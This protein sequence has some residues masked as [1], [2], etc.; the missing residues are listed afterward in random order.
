MFRRFISHFRKYP[1]MLLTI[2]IFTATSSNSNQF[3]KL[4]NEKPNYNK[5]YSTVIT[6]SNNRHFLIEDIKTKILLDILQYKLESITIDENKNIEYHKKE[7]YDC[8]WESKTEE[9]REIC[10]KNLIIIFK[11]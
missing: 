8:I 10:K 3:L 11:N 7:F 2:P 5:D 1:K 9:T 4:L 6:E